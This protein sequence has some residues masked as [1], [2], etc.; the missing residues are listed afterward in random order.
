MHFNKILKHTIAWKLI[1]TALLFLINLL[2]VRLLGVADSGIFFYDIA[3]LS[4]IQLI[5]SMSLESGITFYASKD[6]RTITSILAFILPLLVV[7]GVISWVMLRHIKF[8]ISIHLSVLFILSNLV[9]IYFSAFFH[10]KKWF[11]SLNIITCIVNFV[12]T[13]F[14]IYWWLIKP[15]NEADKN[16]F[17]LTYIVNLSLQAICLVLVILFSTKRSSVS[18]VIITPVAK[19][20]FNYSFIALICNVAFFLVTR[21]D[22][23][24]VQKYCSDIALSNYV[25]VSKFG[26]L[27]ILVPSIIASVVFPYSIGDDG[28]IPVSKVQQLCRAITLIFVPVT[29]TIILTANWIL[30]WLF[31]S[32]FNLMYIALL[33]YL[34][35]FFSLSII[36]VL[37][38]HLAGKKLLRANL[39]ASLLALMI[40]VIGDVLLIPNG[41]I[42][43]AALV[44]STAYLVC[45]IYLLWLYK[46][47]YDCSVTDFFYPNKAEINIIFNQFKKNTTP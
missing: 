45:C 23:F 24:F 6:N 4:F 40:V 26:Q 30:P 12:T 10:A 33:L 32:G 43:A 1:N 31:G 9:L 19:K 29:I 34:P 41:G 46:I 8:S 38:A 27:I 20:I 15:V 11:I 22:Y 14:L 42:N 7:Q 36:T 44:S 47:K 16:Y 28:S 2:M 5:V 13:S 35:G 39:V 21:I 3:V 25:Q 37:A 17:T 18:F